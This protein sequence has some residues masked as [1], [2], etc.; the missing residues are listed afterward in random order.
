MKTNNYKFDLMV[1]NQSN[2]DIT[3]N[4]SLLKV[5]NFLNCSVIDLMDDTPDKLKVS[6]KYILS[7]GEYKNH[8]CYLPHESKKIQY[9][10][11]Q[12]GM[13]IFHLQAKEFLYFYDNN[14]NKISKNNVS[15]NQYTPRSVSKKDKFEG[16][17]DTYQAPALNNFLYLYLNDNTTIDLSKVQ[18]NEITF[19]IK[20]NYQKSYSIVWPDNIL[21]PQK[22]AHK[23]TEQSNSMD[24]I[25]LYKIVE[26]D[27][28]IAEII[29]QNYQYQEVL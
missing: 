26:S 23:M 3:Y 15:Y 28:F 6:E 1:Q 13:V 10:K 5:D 2:K 17:S 27:H 19:L 16:I 21:Q 14:W 24:L 29:N 12:N 11:P 22:Q 25:K 4:E 8:I 18:T 20:Q 9:L 7:K